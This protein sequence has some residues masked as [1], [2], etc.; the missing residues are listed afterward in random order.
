MHFSGGGIPFDCFTFQ[1]AA[2]DL[3]THPLPMGRGMPGMDRQHELVDMSPPPAESKE[4]KSGSDGGS[5]SGSGSG[6]GAKGYNGSGGAKDCRGGGRVSWGDHTENKFSHSADAEAKWSND[7]D[8]EG[9]AKSRSEVL[10]RQSQSLSDDSDSDSEGAGSN[11]MGNAQAQAF[12]PAPLLGVDP[13]KVVAGARFFVEDDLVIVVQAEEV[14]IKFKAAAANSEVQTKGRRWFAANARTAQLRPEP[15]L[16][17]Q[18]QPLPLTGRG[19]V[20]ERAPLRLQ[21]RISKLR[22]ADPS[23]Q[24]LPYPYDG[25]LSAVEQNRLA[26]APGMVAVLSCRV[27]VGQPGIWVACSQ[28]EGDGASLLTAFAADGPKQAAAKWRRHWQGIDASAPSELMTGDMQFEYPPTTA[29]PSTA[30][31]SFEK[32]CKVELLC[33]WQQQKQQQQLAERQLQRYR[34]T[35]RVVGVCR[36]RLLEILAMLHGSS[37]GASEWVPLAFTDKMGRKPGGWVAE[38]AVAGGMGAR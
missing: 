3:S 18:P 11:G 38:L 29:G 28:K 34:V 25:K 35:E 33:Q 17:P 21:L 2:S 37:S 22:P 15:E 7:A 32:E 36:I 10:S 6:S 24:Q 8:Y 19:R 16:Q 26:Q 27:L 14:A 31:G 20:Q 9:F 30:T 1:G 13:A 5:G 4:A 12:T 23:C